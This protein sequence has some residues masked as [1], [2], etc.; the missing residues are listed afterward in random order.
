MAVTDAGDANGIKTLDLRN[1]D[2][3]TTTNTWMIRMENRNDTAT[4]HPHIEFRRTRGANANL[5]NGDDIGGV[6]FHPRFNNNIL[7]AAKFDAVYTGDGTTRVADFVWYL[8]NSAGPAERMRLRA[9]GDLNLTGLTASRVLTTDGDKDLVSSSVTTTTLGFLDATSSIQTQLNGK[10]ATGNYLTALTGDVTASGPG[11]V[12]ATI[13]AGKVTNAM[14][15]GS[16][17]LTSKV[18]G[19]LPIANGGTGQTGATAAFD[20]LAPTTTIGDIIYHNGTDNVRLAGDTTNTKKWLRTLSVAGTATAPS[21]EEVDQVRGQTTGAAIGAGYVGE[22]LVQ[23]QTGVTGINTGA[24]TTVLTALT[25]TA[26]VWDISCMLRCLSTASMTQVD[27]GIATATNSST[28]HIVGDTATTFN[29][30]TG[31]DNGGCIPAVRVSIS[32]TTSY[33]LTAR[34]FGSSSGNYSGRLSAVRIA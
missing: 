22:R 28:G 9:N 4:S 34:P 2:D 8:S 12:V 26:G 25:L 18:T 23:S 16:I 14:L 17:D 6:D 19:A 21:W 1:D 29:M 31:A 27:F 7:S 32:A 5:A 24:Y 13:G 11:S 20:T 15:A 10:Q 30:V 3:L 33:F